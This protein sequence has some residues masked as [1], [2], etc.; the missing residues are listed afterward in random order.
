MSTS[1]DGLDKAEVFAALF[2]KAKPQGLGFLHYNPAPM[3]AEQA[4]ERFGECSEYFDYVDGRVMKVNLS[5]TELETGLYNCDNGA[6]AAEDVI[7]TLRDTGDINSEQSQ[8]EHA[9]NVQE[10]ATFMLEHLFDVTPAKEEGG[11]K[12][13]TLDVG[14]AADDLGPILDDILDENK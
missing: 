5:G 7:A 4:K 8:R 3:T 14:E 6:N 13:I 11:I 2:N 9:R 1:L 12:T 10:S